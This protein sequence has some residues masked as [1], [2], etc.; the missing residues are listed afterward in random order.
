MSQ[1]RLG[2]AAA[3]SSVASASLP[4]AL[5]DLQ[6]LLQNSNMRALA[7]FK[8]ITPLLEQRCPDLLP[9]LANAI[10]T[11][12]FANAEQRLQEIMKREETA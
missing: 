7:A 6:M 9:G 12:D 11:L 8:A 1:K 10:E 5:A 2:Q 4:Q 3:T